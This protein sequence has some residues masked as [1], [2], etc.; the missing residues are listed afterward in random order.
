MATPGDL[1]FLPAGHQCLQD[2]LVEKQYDNPI[3][4][5]TKQNTCDNNNDNNW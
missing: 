5:K 3:T 2:I 4:I 1:H